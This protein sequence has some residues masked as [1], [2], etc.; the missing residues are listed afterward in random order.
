MV[1][2]PELLS[3]T[4]RIL[5]G[6]FNRINCC[7]KKC[8]G[9]ANCEFVGEGVTNHGELAV[10]IQTI[11]PVGA[12]EELILSYY[13]FPS[14]RKLK[15]PEDD[16]FSWEAPSKNVNVGP[17]GVGLYTK[18][19]CF[20]RYEYIC[21]GIGYYDGSE[22]S[23]TAVLPSVTSS[24]LVPHR[25]PNA[26][27]ALVDIGGKKTMPA[28]FSLESIS[29][30]SEVIVDWG[31]RRPVRTVMGVDNPSL[32]CFAS[33]VLQALLCVLSSVVDATDG[34]ASDW[35]PER[36][37]GQRALGVQTPNDTT[38]LQVGACAVFCAL[39]CSSL[40]Y[41]IFAGPMGSSSRRT[42]TFS[43]QYRV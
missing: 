33:A 6:F 18:N 13:D 40:N 36:I 24:S 31:N 17:A 19:R 41:V 11:R 22:N 39:I 4:G 16:F 43:L 14:K 1:S 42:A 32:R 35:F 2:D 12:N 30:G 25:P 7:V 3:P 20:R 23:M 37:T 28:L 15:F 10:A 27:Y 5:I 34:H 9:D 38:Y 8:P 26:I 29:S 21:P